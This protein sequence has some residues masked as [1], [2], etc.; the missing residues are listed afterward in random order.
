M[1]LIEFLFYNFQKITDV[2]TIY[3]RL[4]D[5]DLCH[6]GYL[7][8]LDP[9]QILIGDSVKKKNSIVFWRKE[10]NKVFHFGV[11]YCTFFVKMISRKLHLPEIDDWSIPL[12]WIHLSDPIF[13]TPNRV[14][15][16]QPNQNCANWRDY[17]ILYVIW[18]KMALL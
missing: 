4:G 14:S 17:L 13:W 10:Y 9:C 5:R 8:Q 16:Y 15:I 7:V 6:V 18:W 11:Y 3:C 12:W 2:L 1:I